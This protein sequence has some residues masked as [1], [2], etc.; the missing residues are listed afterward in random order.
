MM[1]NKTVFNRWKE[2]SYVYPSRKVQFISIKPDKSLIAAPSSDE[3]KKQYRMIF[4]GALVKKF[5]TPAVDR[6][7]IIVCRT[8]VAMIEFDHLRRYFELTTWL[9]INI[10]H[11][12]WYPVSDS[13]GPIPTPTQ[14]TQILKAK[15]IYVH[16]A[17]HL[18]N[19]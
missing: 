17:I 13:W 9:I 12:C 7:A 6:A 11:C 18:T 14:C 8:L 15:S 5:K 3:V 19:L 4:V 16:I 10:N 2:T 1:K